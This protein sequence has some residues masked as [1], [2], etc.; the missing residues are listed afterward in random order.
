MDT[1]ADL[2]AFE[3]VVRARLLNA[4]D[5]AAKHGNVAP[6]N[7]ALAEVPIGRLRNASIAWVAK[8]GP[9]AEARERP[10]EFVFSRH[11]KL[12]FDYQS[13]AV[14]P[15]WSSKADRSQHEVDGSPAKPA[16]A[17]RGTERQSSA[18]EIDKKQARAALTRFLADPDVANWK[19]I[20]EMC[21]DYQHKWS[22]KKKHQYVSVVQGGLPSLGKG[23]R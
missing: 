11:A 15:I 9:V 8:F 4:I 19:T 16:A 13:A 10:G 3:R 21:A 12:T 22:G 18:R 20:L 17:V 1:Q 5:S 2:D 6:I 23:S 7:R 14:T